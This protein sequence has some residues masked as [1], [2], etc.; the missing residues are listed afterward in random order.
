VE[1]LRRRLVCSLRL[2]VVA[3]RGNERQRCE[4]EQANG[5]ATSDARA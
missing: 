5:T 2:G 3:A 4:S 1:L